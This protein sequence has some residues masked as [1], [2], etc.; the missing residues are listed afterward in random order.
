MCSRVFEGPVRPILMTFVRGRT[1]HSTKAVGESRWPW[2]KCVRGSKADWDSTAVR[3]SE[4][5]EFWF[6]CAAVG[7]SL[8][9]AGLVRCQALVREEV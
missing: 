6:M 7:R 2:F 3:L 9:L 4:I 8:P 1:L 5:T